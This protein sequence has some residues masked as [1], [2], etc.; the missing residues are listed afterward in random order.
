MQHTFPAINVSRADGCSMVGGRW[1]S[2]SEY[3]V[4]AAS[5]G[6]GTGSAQTRPRAP[7]GEAILHWCAFG[8][9]AAELAADPAPFGSLSRSRQL[10]RGPHHPPLSLAR[11]RSGITSAL[12][13]CSLSLPSERS[14]RAVWSPEGSDNVALPHRLCRVVRPRLCSDLVNVAVGA[15]GRSGGCHGP[16][17]RGGLYRPPAN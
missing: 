10:C 1:D 7:A 15:H 3:A 13:I 12:Q 6:G 5:L 17:L 14:G 16:I 11:R 9:R 8:R 2:L 4:L